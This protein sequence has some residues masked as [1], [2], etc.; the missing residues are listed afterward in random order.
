MVV[1]WEEHSDG[2]YGVDNGISQ[3]NIYTDTEIK[4]QKFK[5]VS[6]EDI[7][8]VYCITNLCVLTDTEIKNTV[9]YEICKM[10]PKTVEPTAAAIYNILCKNTSYDSETE[11]EDNYVGEGMFLGKLKESLL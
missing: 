10:E 4:I 1:I 6:T 5:K 2:E 9:T 3:I 7:N 8:F 11:N